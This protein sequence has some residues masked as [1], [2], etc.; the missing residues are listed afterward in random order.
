MASLLSFYEITARAKYVPL[1]YIQN[2][3]NKLISQGIYHDTFLNILYPSSWDLDHPDHI[4]VHV[5]EN[6]KI[7]SI[8]IPSTYT[9]SLHGIV[10][11][12]LKCINTGKISPLD[13][14]L[15]LK[16]TLDWDCFEICDLW[17]SPSPLLAHIGTLMI[18]AYSHDPN[19]DTSH[20]EED[21]VN[22][23]HRWIN[24]S[25]S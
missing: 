21:I 23:A 7:L 3:F 19:L 17:D 15:A 1:H 22:T 6:L 2:I 24:K 25:S 10:E 13:G 8:K 5:K 16:E 4:N 12:H 14:M 20:I 18:Q 11:F 9:D